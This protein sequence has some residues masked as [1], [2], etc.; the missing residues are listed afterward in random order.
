VGQLCWWQVEAKLC[1]NVGPSEAVL[2][3][4]GLI[5]QSAHIHTSLPTIFQFTYWPIQHTVYEDSLH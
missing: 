1:R 4:P 3:T 5:H 2:D